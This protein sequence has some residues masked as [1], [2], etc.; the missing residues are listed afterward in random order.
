MAA[1]LALCPSLGC[2]PDADPAGLSEAQAAAIRDSVS[3]ALDAFRERGSGPDPTA[4]GGSYS[5]SPAFR[6]YESGAMR[7]ESA[8]GRAK[9]VPS[10]CATAPGAPAVAPPYWSASTIS[11]S[12]ILGRRE[13]TRSPARSFP[14]RRRCASSPGRTDSCPCPDRRRTRLGRRSRG[15][16]SLWWRI[17]GRTGRRVR[18]HCRPPR[19]QAQVRHEESRS[20]RA[21]CC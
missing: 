20:R 16:A 12:A 19:P 13:G 9:P 5:D 17:G 4:V 18:R 2:Q 21:S 14:G 8:A 3:I 15:C 1:F 7:Y 6:L 10:A 11:P